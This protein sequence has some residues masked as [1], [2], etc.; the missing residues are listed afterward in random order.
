MIR[1]RKLTKK[2]RPKMVGINKKVERR[3]LRREEKAERAAKIDK[4][5]EQELL[6]CVW[7]RLCVCLCD[8][9]C[10][11]CLS[12]VYLEVKTVRKPL[13]NYTHRR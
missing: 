10:L 7:T 13:V 4:S 8:F 2:V 3:E 6:R 12:D 9:G 11:R 5:I 1:M